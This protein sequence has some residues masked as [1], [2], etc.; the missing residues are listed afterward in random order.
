M[1]QG[2]RADI[3][4]IIMYSKELEAIIEAAL[5]DG[6]LT[7][8]EREV[9]HRRA[10]QEDV[11]ADELDVILDAKLQKIE[12]ASDAASRRRKSKKC[13]YCG[14]SILQLTEQCP[15]CGESVTAEASEELQEIF[16]NLEEALVDLKEEKKYKRNKAIV[17]RYVRK[18]KMYYGS[19]PKVQILLEEIEKETEKAEKRAKSS[20]TK[21]GFISL[22][23]NTWIWLILEMF[24]FSGLI[25][26][27]CTRYNEASDREQQIEAQLRAHPDYNLDS[28]ELRSDEYKKINA[29][30]DIAIN[31]RVNVEGTGLMYI[32][33]GI[34]IIVPTAIYAVRKDKRKNN[35]NTD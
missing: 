6:V 10:A 15:H 5:A 29:D 20:E 12:Q 30:L 32:L 18:A 35:S 17:E 33:M 3:V 1:V 24:I 23:K 21:Q 13:P 27:N 25:F 4:F 22:I 34:I 31:E 14:G 11:D 16:D 28:N 8:K 26:N 2:L 19:N 7:D 9:L